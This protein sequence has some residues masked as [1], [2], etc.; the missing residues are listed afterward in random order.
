MSKTTASTSI[1]TLTTDWGQSDYYCGMLK[2]RMISACSAIQIVDI[3][4]NVPSFNI[5]HASFVLRHSYNNFPRNT[6]HIV[7]VNSED[8]VPSRLLL[9]ENEGHFFIM[10]DNGMLDLLFATPPE[11]VYTI[12]FDPSGSFAS[13]NVFVDTVTKIH[14]GTP[15]KSIGQIITD[16]QQK[17]ALRATIDESIITGSII[18][19]DSYRNAITNI[20]RSLFDRVGKGRKFNIFVQSN[21]NKITELSLTY[22]QVDPGELLAVFNSTNLLEIAIRNGYASELLSLSIG[23]TVRI[24]FL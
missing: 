16:Y 1:V 22:N 24:N 4:H 19:I 14:N 15:L 11:T 17:I 12:P 13:L 6:I 9:L 3:S 18:Y 21:H 20:S 7:M 5:H 23:G 8:T 2:G 10:P